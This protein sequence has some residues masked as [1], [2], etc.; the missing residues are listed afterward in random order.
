MILFAANT[1]AETP[2]AFN[3]NPYN[4]PLQ[5][6]GDLD[7]IYYMVPWAHVRQS[8][9][10]K[11]HLDR[12]SRFCTAHSCHT[13]NTR[14]TLRTCDIC[15]DRCGLII[16]RTDVSVITTTCYTTTRHYQRCKHHTP[17]PISP[18]PTCTS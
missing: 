10:H 13:T 12:F 6:G 14:T 4:C 16:A 11:R 15:R 5:R 18:L 8:S 9:A 17:L 1:A 7:P 3:G 2:N